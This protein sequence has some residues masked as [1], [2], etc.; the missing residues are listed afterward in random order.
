[1]NALVAW[2]GGLFLTEGKIGVL[3][4]SSLFLTQVG[5]YVDVCVC[6]HTHT[7]CTNGVLGHEPRNLDETPGGPKEY[8]WTK[9][10]HLHQERT[11]LEVQ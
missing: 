9:S 3:S 2:R 8:R 6:I 5:V 7:H 1:M 4:I 11:Q 10:R